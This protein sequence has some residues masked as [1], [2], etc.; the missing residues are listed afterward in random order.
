MFYLPFITNKTE[1]I[2]FKSGCVIW[3]AKHLKR[4][5]CKHWTGLLEWW[6]G[7]LALFKALHLPHMCTHI[8][9]VLCAGKSIKLLLLNEVTYCIY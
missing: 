2:S 4:G 5:V 7:G 6:N 9:M 3:V 8:S 1:H